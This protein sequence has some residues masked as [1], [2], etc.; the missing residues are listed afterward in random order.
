MI[1]EKVITFEKATQRAQ[2]LC[3]R[4]E[5]CSYDIQ[6]KLR[7]WKLSSEDIDKI[8]KKLNADNFINDERY[9]YMFA[10]DKS[11]FSKWG[12][13]KI[14]YAL[15]SKHIPDEIIKSAVL[16]TEASQDNKSLLDLLTRKAKTLKAKSIYDL[17]A[18]LIR[19]GI[20]RGYD[21]GLVNEKVS[22]IIKE[23]LLGNS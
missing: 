5:R 20:S 12:P 9:A 19:F 6:A 4:Q 22:S 13:I 16:E 17:K 8:I 1:K 10:R 7:L 14:T 15:K 21:Y 18:K 3:A 11:K 23:S 2:S